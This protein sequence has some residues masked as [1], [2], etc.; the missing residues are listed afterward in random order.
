MFMGE[1]DHTIDAKG[2][3]IMPSKFRTDLGEQF[4][5][6]M[7]LDGCLFVYPNEEW[8]KFVEELK[9]LP[10]SREARQLQRYFMAGAIACE[11]DKQGR[12]LIPSKLR[13]HACLEKEVVFVGVLSKIEI[14]SK[15]RWEENN[16]YGNMDEIADHMSSFG[17][18]F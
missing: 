1:Y 15:E 18:S 6:T 17:L 9:K 2:R 7:G 11:V 14:W 3:I 4:V 12:V 8:M 10:G 16:T 13:E 5:I